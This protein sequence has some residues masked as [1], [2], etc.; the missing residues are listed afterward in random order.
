MVQF[1]GMRKIHVD[2]CS[3][4]E[5][6]IAQYFYNVS[7][8]YTLNPLSTISDPHCVMGEMNKKFFG[9]CYFTQQ[10]T[11]QFLRCCNLSLFC[12]AFVS[13]HSS[14]TALTTGQK[15]PFSQKI[16]HFGKKGNSICMKHNFC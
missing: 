1:F 12:Q 3:L 16:E 5:C 9:S 4:H 14:H 15:L 2:I 11:L 6:S 10:V 8:I 13:L 7:L